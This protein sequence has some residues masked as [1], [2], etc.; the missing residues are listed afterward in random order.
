MNWALIVFK[1]EW[2]EMLRDK[3]VRKTM[4]VGPIISVCVTM[5]LFAVIFSSVDKA[6]KTTIHVVKSA[7]DPAVSAF[8]QVLDKA[9]MKVEEVASV[10]E[11]KKQ[12]AK[13][14]IR[15]ALDFGP[16]RAVQRI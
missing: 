11:A 6:A 7:P 5:M 2:R 4:I 10:E 14:E 15:L 9:G 8:L 12:I 16:R 13:G 1:K 3:R